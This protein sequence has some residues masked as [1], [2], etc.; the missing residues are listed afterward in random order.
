MDE[1]V[2]IAEVGGWMDGMRWDVMGGVFIK[3]EIILFY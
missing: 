1:C 2:G 3:V